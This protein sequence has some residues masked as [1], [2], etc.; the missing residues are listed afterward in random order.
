[1]A[2]FIQEL[3]PQAFIFENVKGL[4]TAKRTA[5]GNP[6]EFWKEIWMEFNDI[7]TIPPGKEKKL[8][9]VVQWKKLLAKDYCFT[10]LSSHSQYHSPICLGNVLSSYMGEVGG[11]VESF[12]MTVEEQASRRLLPAGSCAIYM[13]S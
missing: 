6:K 12:E 4:L 5:E 11:K 3:A 1:M 9:Y 7:R 8:R 10:Q 2:K 13:N